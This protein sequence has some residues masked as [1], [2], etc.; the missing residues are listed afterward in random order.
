MPPKRKLTALEEVARLTAELA[1]QKR[2][3]DLK[4]QELALERA[5][6]P[7]NVPKLIPRA[8]GQAGRIQQELPFFRRFQGGWPIKD[9]IKQYLQ[10]C[11]DKRKRDLH[12]ERLAESEDADDWTQPSSSRSRKR[13][14]HDNGPGDDEDEEDSEQQNEDDAHEKGEFGASGR[15]F[16]NWMDIPE[17]VDEV[18]SDGEGG[19]K[20]V[21]GVRW[22]DEGE[23]GGLE[24]TPLT[25]DFQLQQ[26]HW[27]SEMELEFH[28]TTSRRTKDDNKENDP[29]DDEDDD[30]HHS[31]VRKSKSAKLIKQQ[32]FEQDTPPPSLK[33]KRKYVEP[34]GDIAPVTKKRKIQAPKNNTPS[35]L[36]QI[37]P[38]ALAKPVSRKKPTPA[39]SIA[40]LHP[41]LPL[42]NLPDLFP[43]AYCKE[44]VPEDPTPELLSLFKQKQDLVAKEGKNAPGRALL[45]VQICQTITLENRSAQL[46]REAQGQAWPLTIDFTELPNRVSMLRDSIVDLATDPTELSATTIWQL[47]L[48]DIQYKVFTFTCAPVGSFSA[49][50]ER[51][52][53][54]GYFGPRGAEIMAR[55][56]DQILLE[57]V[58]PNQICETI[59]SLINTPHRWDE[60]IK[61]SRLFSTRSFVHYI[62][63]PFAA[64][65]LISDDLQIDFDAALVVQ[66][67]SSEFGDAFNPVQFNRN[68]APPRVTAP[69]TK[70]SQVPSAGDS[71]RIVT[72]DDF[73]GPSVK[74]KSDLK[75]LADSTGKKPL[76]SSSHTYPTRYR[77]AKR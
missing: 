8:G 54:C 70:S 27:D 17:E 64:A 62:L 23:D 30:T 3:L 19:S 39:P 1:K 42:A 9:L 4:D 63:V 26:A 21:P 65:C 35:A 25:D 6:Q 36:P 15:K 66:A 38:K 31:P 56:V 44:A 7:K 29:I 58:L 34:E 59:L 22:G 61:Q 74:K 77:Q 55:A 33:S 75:K 72:L 18:A 28:Q 43:G 5:N 47:F 60:P 40:P 41:N 32:H 12:A 76:A 14:A 51:A 71:K 24:D 53:R 46:F 2:Q 69:E 57:D 13:N 45:N 10:N 50:A 48:K 49:A 67:H 16:V 73:P 37:H 20:M 11:G 52:K 68:V